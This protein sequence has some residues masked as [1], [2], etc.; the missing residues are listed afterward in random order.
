MNEKFKNIIIFLTIFAFLAGL[1]YYAF[2]TSDF[3]NLKKVDTSMDFRMKEKIAKKRYYST[4]VEIKENGIVDLGDFEIN[5]G[6]GKKVI[7]NISAK[8]D[9]PDGWGMA[10]GVDDEIKSKSTVIRHSVIEAIMNQHESDVRSYKVK[11]AII[12]NINRNLSNTTV[13]DVY[14][15]RLIIAE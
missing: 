9:K 10:I 1:V 4:A 3:S 7:A 11:E 5:I 2:V 13:E 12:S 6:N 8:Y 15:N 14:F